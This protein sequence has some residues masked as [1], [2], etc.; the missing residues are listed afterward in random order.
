MLGLGW[1]RADVA[2]GLRAFVGHSLG[3]SLCPAVRLAWTAET[4]V[5]SRGQPRVG[6]S[7]HPVAF[8]P[9]SWLVRRRTC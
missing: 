2:G 9:L 4:D 3:S 5:A 6:L 1:D 8:L 7:R